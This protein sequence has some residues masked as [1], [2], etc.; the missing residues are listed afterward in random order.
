MPTLTL[1]LAF[2]LGRMK[3]GR[4]SEVASSPNNH[5]FRGHGGVVRE[6]NLRS[7]HKSVRGNSPLGSPVVSRGLQGP[8]VDDGT[9][10]R[11]SS[12]IRHGD[13]N[14]NGK[15]TVLITNHLSGRAQTFPHGYRNFH[16]NSR[17]LRGSKAHKEQLKQKCWGSQPMQYSCCLVC[18]S[19]DFASYEKYYIYHIS[20]I[21]NIYIY[22]Y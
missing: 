20:Y 14:S 5:S 12:I 15:V 7:G 2:A 19:G 6:L 4:S 10:Y 9:D 3:K 22:I 8:P 13:Q 17:R 18:L 1:T 21:I 16:S 11:Y